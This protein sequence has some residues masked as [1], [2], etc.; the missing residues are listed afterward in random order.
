MSTI[1]SDIDLRELAIDR[2]G[3]AGGSIR[4][5]RPVLTRLVLPI[6]L[7]AGFVALVVWAS[8]DY[9]MPP[10][11]VTVVP[12]IPSTAEVRQE[13]T[14]LFK[15]AGWIEPRPTPVRVAA[16]AP[17]VVEKLLV[18][19]DDIVKPNQEIALLVKDDA[20]LARDRARADRKLRAAE[21]DQAKADLKAATTRLKQPVHLEATLRTAESELAK[22]ERMIADLPHAKKR[23]ELR[24]QFAKQD[25]KGKIASKGAV[26]GISIERAK[27]ERDS[28]QALVQE[29]TGRMKS[30]AQ[31]R[32]ALKARC[33]AL[34][35]Q[36][37]LLADEKKAEESAKAKV[38]A[39]EAMLERADVALAEAELR[40]KRMTIRSPIAGRVYRL[41]GHPGARVGGGGSM[42]QMAG[43][44]GSTVVTLYRPDMLQVRVDVRFEDIP[45]VSLHQPVRIENAALASPLTGKVLFISSEADIQKNTLQVKVEITNPPD[46]FKPE[47][48]VDVT[49]LA[50]KRPDSSSQPTRVL[51]LYVPRQLVHQSEEGSFVWVA[52]QSAGVARNV[53]VE[54]GVAAGN[55]LVEVKKGLTV[56][57]RVISTGID[58]LRDGDR[59]RIVG[60]DTS[61]GANSAPQADR[62]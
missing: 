57:S 50:P 48:L 46:V 3:A 52:D 38:Q 17:G 33:K 34:K 19:E 47:M 2:G 36:L 41:I 11:E 39:A 40:L 61:F 28:A 12:V 27:T 37:T 30:L 54:T 35:T 9:L 59:I 62:K 23:A 5:R 45:H 21:L 25:L 7:L 32:T 10:K 1:N 16:L 44:D 58:G 15:A 53:Q 4:V 24:L 8:W 43:H 55:G 22:V 6:V 26:A 31:E 20:K 56:S 13:G 60:E 49:F 51:R 42:T 29:L 14:P 18:R